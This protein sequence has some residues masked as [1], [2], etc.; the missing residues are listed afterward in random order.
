MLTLV[1]MILMGVQATLV[2]DLFAI[3]LRRLKIIH[4]LILSRSSA[5]EENHA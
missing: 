2:M 1:E 5:Q 3:P 4:P